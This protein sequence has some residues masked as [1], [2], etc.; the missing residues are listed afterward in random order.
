MITIPRINLEIEV[1]HDREA[2][3]TISIKNAKTKSENI[4]LIK[5]IKRNNVRGR[6]IPG[7]RQVKVAMKTLLQ[8]TRKIRKHLDQHLVC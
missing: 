5:D 1:H 4:S 8:M 3:V 6:D 7:P 2:G